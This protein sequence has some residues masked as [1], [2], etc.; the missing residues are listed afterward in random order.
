MNRITL[1][2]IAVVG[3]S[4]C[5]K[6]EPTPPAPSSAPGE[7]TSA[8]ARPEKLANGEP[9]VITVKHV[10]IAFEGAQRSEQKR[11]RA[12][13]EKVAFEVVNRAKSGEDFDK[14]MKELSND[15][16]EGT[17][18]LVNHGV[19]AKPGEFERSGMVA[20]FGD[21]G[22]R[23]AVGEVGLADYDPKGSPFGLHVIKRVK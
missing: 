5:G 10:L 23:M 4:S 21:V 16:G 15:P 13:A 12:E 14:I 11:T 6:K 20:A 9:A 2:L 18:T 22:F 3:L 1:V 17:Y 19:T 7:G 8:E